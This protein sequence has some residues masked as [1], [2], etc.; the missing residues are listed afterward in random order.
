MP[1]DRTKHAL[2]SRDVVFSGIRDL[3]LSSAL[4]RLR[5]TGVS[6]KQMQSSRRTMNMS[7]MKEFVTTQLK[8]VQAQHKSLNTRLCPS[9]APNAHCF[10][11]L[12][13][14]DISACEA[15]MKKKKELQFAEQLQ[16]EQN[17]V[18]VRELREAAD[19]VESFIVRQ[20]DPLAAL[21]LLSLL[22]IVQDGLP[23]KQYRQWCRLFTQSFGHEHIV[24]LSNLRKLRLFWESTHSST[25]TGALDASLTR[26]RFRD[27][28]KRFSLIPRMPAEGSTYDL[29]K[30]RD[31]AFVFGGAYT[32]LVVPLLDSLLLN[33]PTAVKKA[34]L[35]AVLPV[36]CFDRWKACS[37]SCSTRQAGSVRKLLAI[38]FVGGVTFAEV[39]AVR[40]WAAARGVQLLVLTTGVVNGS[41]VMQ[42][43]TPN[44]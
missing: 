6:L 43:L 4:D 39:A 20:V 5:E 21:R 26:K 40:S 8:E 14:T 36:H 2:D 28:C 34:D 30:P 31:S 37:G 29:K 1:P 23:V 16:A 13:L 38:W 7:D 41:S 11:F 42:S 9:Y 10:L 27:M 17:M 22:C 44:Q 3:H 18:Q 32:P 25:L 24:T 12:F 19:F 35:A 33:H 15:V